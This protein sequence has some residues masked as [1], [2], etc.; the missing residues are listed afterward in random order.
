MNEIDAGTPFGKRVFDRLEND[1]IGW[2]V[3]VDESGTP[4]PSPVWFYWQE[5]G[6][7]IYSQPNKGKLSNI[8]RSPR[9]AVHLDADEQGG[10]IVILTGSATID[11]SAPKATG[12][13]EYIAKYHEHIL[14]LG[15]T[16]E[17]FADDYSVAIRFTPEKLRGH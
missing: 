4:R 10:N 1:L 12:V 13:P 3:T 2:L 7:L 9:V 8:E 5:E 14:R 16:D 6:M 17:M 15:A 11:S